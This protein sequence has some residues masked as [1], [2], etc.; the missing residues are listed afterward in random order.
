MNREVKRIK[1]DLPGPKQPGFLTRLQAAI[2]G[3]PW[4]GQIQETI[5]SSI[6]DSYHILNHTSKDSDSTERSKTIG[7]LDRI[8]EIRK[9]YKGEAQ[10]G[11]IPC[12][13]VIQFNGT[14]QMANGLI[15]LPTTDDGQAS[16]EV[17]VAQD[18]IDFNNLNEEMGLMLAS[19]GELSGQV[20][21]R[22][23]WDR[24]I[25][26]VKTYLVPLLETKYV[27]AYKEGDYT[28]VDHVVL[29]PDTELEERVPG[30]QVVFIK[31]RG[32]ING[33]Y[34]VPT[35][36]P[37]L[38]EM[39]DI[40]KARQDL[41]KVNHLF[42]FPTPIFT[43]AN[44]QRVGKINTIINALNWKIGKAL[45]LQ[46]SESLKYA[47]IMGTGSK[48]LREEI[49][50]LIQHISSVTDVPV[51]FL[52][53]P[54]LLSNRSTSDSMFE[55]PVKRAMAT[56][57]AW[58]GGL[59]ELLVK[60]FGMYNMQATKTLDPSLVAIGFPPIRTGNVKDVLGAWLPLKVSKNISQRT[61]L[62]KIGV[63]NPEE[64]IQ[65]LAQE[66]EQEEPEG[67]EEDEELTQAVAVAEAA[68]A[69]EGA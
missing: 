25:E 6:V 48:E 22:W 27:V 19:E 33:S 36:M 49:T 5:S 21:L 14:F 23:R 15:A 41:R 29:Y 24:D 63:E 64:E 46:E 18:F 60:V 16:E 3:K 26:M 42:A 55:G 7:R 47:E 34:G 39:Q 44:E 37:C 31:F 35:P 10:W 32:I 43:A 56:Q 51:H 12:S 8:A 28:Q 13:S 53:H 11:N 58:M 45:V 40:D 2:T 66:L 54:E 50:M 68:A 62:E 30:H 20:L 65:R 67:G 69:A 1:L 17:A 4:A 57:R 61:F 52:G 38:E 9:M 59:E